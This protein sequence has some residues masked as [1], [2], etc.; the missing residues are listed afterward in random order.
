MQKLEDL[1]S[2]MTDF[3]SISEQIAEKEAKYQKHQ[4]KCISLGLKIETARI[5]AK[6]KLE[7]QIHAL[8]SEVGFQKARFE[9]AVE[10]QTGSPGWLV[11][12]KEVKP[13]P[14]G[15]NKVYF[16][17]QTNPGMPAGP[18][19][20]IAS[21]GEIARVMLAIK[22]A[23]AEKSEF[24]VLIF[25]EIDTGISGEIANKVGVVMR[26]LADSFQILSIT[27]LPQIAAKGHHHFQIYKRIE[28]KSD[29]FGCQCFESGESGNRTCQ[30]V[31]WRSA[32]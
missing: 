30:N 24:P 16:L 22:A 14:S 31:V 29:Y 28:G 15:L 4:E 13:S 18:L 32:F 1:R 8:L 17:I 9:V 3:E 25:D 11:E 27:H 19:S 20:Q 6:P 12:G 7:K 5:K 21:G 10:R 2:Q 23:L 26:K